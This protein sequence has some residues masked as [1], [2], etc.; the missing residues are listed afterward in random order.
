MIGYVENKVRCRNQILLEYFGEIKYDPCGICDTCISHKKEAKHSHEI[1]Y[2]EQILT[3][4]SEH[5]MDLDKIEEELSTIDTHFLAE[6]IREMIDENLI[7][8]NDHWQLERVS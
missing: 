3:I 5:P 8:Y 6:I 7:R 1:N 2:K 4:L